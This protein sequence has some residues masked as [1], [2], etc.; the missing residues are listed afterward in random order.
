MTNLKRVNCGL[1]FINMILVLVNIR[2]DKK[3]RTSI[4]NLSKLNIKQENVLDIYEKWPHYK[5]D[6]IKFI[7]NKQYNEV[8]IYGLG[9]LGRLIIDE[10]L[11]NDIKI[12]YIVDQNYSNNYKG[13]PCFQPSGCL[14]KADLM[15]VTVPYEA[16]KIKQE[17]KQLVNFG[18]ES[19]QD[20]L[21]VVMEY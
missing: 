17:M 8:A 4:M 13:I 9:R 6:I 15:I 21:F 2:K 19:V 12:T 5:N 16:D 18:V 3:S 1:I 11:E 20:I 10:Y 7:H 14:P